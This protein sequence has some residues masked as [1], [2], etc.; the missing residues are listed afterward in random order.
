MTVFNCSFFHNRGTGV[1][2][3][4][5]RGNTG[6]LAIT[7]NLMSSFASNPNITVTSCNFINNSA[8]ATVNFRSSNQVFGSGIFTGRGGAMAVFVREHYFNITAYVYDCYFENN[9]ARSYAGSIYFL[10]TGRGSHYGVT[11]SCRY[12]NNLAQQGG[13]GV[14]FVGTKGNQNAPNTFRAINCT[15]IGNKAFIG[16]GLYYSI[17]LNGEHTNIAHFDG[18]TFL[19]NSLS[20]GNDGFGAAIAVDVADNYNDKRSFPVNTMTNT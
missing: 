14:V 11:D 10:L 3:E 8:L 17:N 16:A 13:A 9:M 7:Y 4:P 12:V 20:N 15:F 6:A 5:Y 1:I 2:Q 18:N 19:Y